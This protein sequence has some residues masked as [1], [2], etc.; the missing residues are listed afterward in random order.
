MD[1]K[2]KPPMVYNFFDKKVPGSGIDMNANNEHP[3]DLATQKLAKELHK[4][5]VRKL[6]KTTV[7]SRSK[8]N[9]WSANLA[10]MQLITTFNKRFR[11]FLC[12]IN[13]FSRY[14]WVVPLKGKKGATVTN[15][16]QKN[17]KESKDVA[18]ASPKDVG[19]ASPKDLNQNKIWVDKGSD[20]YNN[21]FKKMV[22]R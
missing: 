3:L 21:S 6:K 13:I 14:A 19:R 8:D 22:K 11:F 16:F 7:Y 17:L 5:I 20:F 1:I 4:Q 9:I 18:R 12:I 15:D 2:G 10:D